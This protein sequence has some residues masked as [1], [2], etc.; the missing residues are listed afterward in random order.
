MLQDAM[1]GIWG[2]RKD[3][4]KDNYEIIKALGLRGHG[5]GSWLYFEKYAEGF[6]PATLSEAEV[7]E[8]ADAM[9]NLHMMMQAIYENRLPDYKPGM[10]LL[11]WYD[12]KTKFLKKGCL[13][14]IVKIRYN[15]F[16]NSYQCDGGS[17]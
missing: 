4:S 8:L 5:D 15:H 14:F 17:P 13:V 16:Y 12:E 2:A 9:G 6:Y 7:E 3:V 10:M 1:I 11:R